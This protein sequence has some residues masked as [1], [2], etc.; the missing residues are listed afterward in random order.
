VKSQHENKN[1]KEADVD[2]SK[3]DAESIKQ[4]TAF[5]PS[6]STSS[7]LR[8]GSALHI[9][10]DFQDPME[11]V[12]HSCDFDSI[13]LVL[14]SIKCADDSEKFHPESHITERQRVKAIERDVEVMKMRE[15]MAATT[16]ENAKFV[17]EEECCEL[18][19]SIGP[20][21]N[22]LHNF[23]SHNL[24]TK[25][26]NFLEKIDSDMTPHDDDGDECERTVMAT[27][28]IF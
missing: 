9:E 13:L 2:D 12:R 16:E 18:L 17:I 14:H 25:S 27:V 6:S 5:A 10:G 3:I 23:A 15:Q 22:W 21:W 11:V 28:S 1:E 24:Q 19:K 4:C 26:F 20:P 7:L 8:C